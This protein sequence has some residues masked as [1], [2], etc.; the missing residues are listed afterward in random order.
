MVVAVIPIVIVGDVIVMLIGI[1]MIIVMVIFILHMD[2]SKN[3]V[4]L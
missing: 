3:R 4:G 2:V 1:I